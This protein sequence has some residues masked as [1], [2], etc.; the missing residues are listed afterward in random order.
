MEL[1]CYSHFTGDHRETQVQQLVRA[2]ETVIVPYAAFQ[3]FRFETML[4]QNVKV[5]KKPFHSHGFLLP[6]SR[7]QK[8]VLE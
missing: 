3:S 4:S 7:K 5:N 8:F 1:P 6:Y 2:T